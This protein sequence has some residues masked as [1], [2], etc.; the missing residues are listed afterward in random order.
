MNEK[1][2]ERAE[3]LENL[4]E[5]AWE[6]FNTRREYEWKVCLALW[7]AMAAFIGTLL[8]G[9]I[10]LTR[11]PALMTIAVAMAILVLHICWLSGLIKAHAADKKVNLFFANTLTEKIGVSFDSKLSHELKQT[12]KKWGKLW[13]WNSLFQIGITALLAAAAVTAVWTI[14]A[15][16]IPAT[17]QPLSFDKLLILTPTTNHTRVMMETSTNLANWFTATNGI[18]GSPDTV[19]FFRINMAKLNP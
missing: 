13:D 9:K 4:R 6:S 3:V 8:T 2:K 19:R 10:E 17:P 11:A 14:G 5:G 7:T 12:R 15:K 16:P 1:E 18:Y